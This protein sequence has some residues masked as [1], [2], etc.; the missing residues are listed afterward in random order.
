MLVVTLVGD[1]LLETLVLVLVLLQQLVLEL[2]LVLEGLELV[3][4]VL[5][6][7]PGRLFLEQGLFVPVERVD[8]VLES[9]DLFLVTTQDQ[10]VLVLLH[11]DDVVHRLLLALLQVLLEFCLLLLVGLGLVSLV[12]LEDV[13]FFLQTGVSLAELFQESL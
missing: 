1:L 7:G 9:V 6:R 4:V 3:G 5:P 8:L 11:F 10:V 13:V 2:E 12:G